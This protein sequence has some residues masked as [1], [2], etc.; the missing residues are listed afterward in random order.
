VVHTMGQRQGWKHRAGDYR[1]HGQDAAWP[2]AKPGE[3]RHVDGHLTLPSMIAIEYSSARQLTLEGLATVPYHQ[4]RIS[5]RARRLS[6]SDG[7]KLVPVST[8]PQA[9]KWPTRGL[10]ITVLAG[11]SIFAVCPQSS[12]SC[13][14]ATFG[15]SALRPA[16]IWSVVAPAD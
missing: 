9:R 10:E 4:T 6:G 14:R 2:L 5:A 8:S 15:W 13:G 1:T 3:L 11:S 7:N 16:P 12:V